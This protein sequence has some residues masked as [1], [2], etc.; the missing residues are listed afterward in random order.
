MTGMAGMTGTIPTIPAIPVITNHPAAGRSTD[1]LSWRRAWSVIRDQ[2]AGQ[3]FPPAGLR[4]KCPEVRA[5]GTAVAVVGGLV[6]CLALGQDRVAAG[7]G[8][9]LDGLQEQG[10]ELPVVGFARRTQKGDL[11]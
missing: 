6:R 3:V 8:R 7:A 5:R 9:V 11:L 2:A 1:D 4:T 10:P